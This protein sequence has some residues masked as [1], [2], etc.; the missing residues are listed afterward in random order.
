MDTIFE[1]AFRRFF[2]P[3]FLWKFM[4]I[5][6]IGSEGSLKKSIQILNNTITEAQEE[7]NN[8]KKDE[9]FDD[10]LL[11]TFM[12]KVQ[13]NGHILPSS[14]IMGTILDILL[15]GRDSVATSA[16]WFFWLVMNNPRVEEKIVHEII[17]V[18]KKTRGE[19]MGGSKVTDSIESLCGEETQEWMK[20]PL[21]YEEVNSLVYTLLE[22][23]RLYPAIPKIVRYAICDDIVPDGTYVPAGSDI[24]LSLYSVGR[25]KSV[26]GED[27]LKF[28][29]ERWLSTDEKRIERHEDGYKFAAFN[30]GSRICIAKYLTYLE[31]KSV[32][33]AILLRYELSHV[34][35]HQVTSKLSFTISMM[36][37]L[38]VN[39]KR[40]DLSDFDVV[41]PK[42]RGGCA[43]SKHPQPPTSRLWVRVI[44][45]EKKRKL[46]GRVGVK[47]VT[48]SIEP[49]YGKETQECME[50][51]LLY[52][53][54]NNLV[55]LHAT[56][57]ETLRVYRT[58]SKIVRYVT[59]DDI[60]QN[61][62]H[63]D[64]Y[65]FATFDGGSRICIAKYLT[66]LEMKSIA[67]AILLHYEL[68]HVLGHQVTSKLSFTIA[69]KNGLK[70]NLKRHD[71]SDFDVI[72]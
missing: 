43:D 18:L 32:A 7:R 56:L 19:D 38:K 37:G 6:S 25:M 44:K 70:I 61:G 15:A 20:D 63:E 36:N 3:N 39:L 68:S 29:P 22:T 50:D 17:T 11:W 28:K 66:Y 71:L 55:Y 58:I 2:Y 34:P 45:G 64:G 35:G 72:N 13:V 47:K 30:G 42:I 26:W 60:L 1:F 10:D 16:S 4:K 52:E 21:T 24:I 23:L 41:S 53:E 27:C 57:L 5:F 59:Y 9:T 31:M 46:L 14:A 8:R 69:M 51:P 33:S 48:H 49:P 54:T 40:R 67:S 62:T 12:K 65:K